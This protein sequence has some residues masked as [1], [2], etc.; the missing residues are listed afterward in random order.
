[1]FRQDTD[2]RALVDDAI[3]VH[4]M[5]RQAAEARHRRLETSVREI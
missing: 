2:S 3:Q 5:P 1:M 4:W